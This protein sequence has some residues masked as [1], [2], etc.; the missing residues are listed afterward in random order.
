MMLMNLCF[1]GIHLQNMSVGK[2]VDNTL[3]LHMLLMRFH[4]LDCFLTD[5]ANNDVFRS[6]FV[7]NVIYMVSIS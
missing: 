3:D 5:I 4:C 2:I 7:F 1:P 6:G